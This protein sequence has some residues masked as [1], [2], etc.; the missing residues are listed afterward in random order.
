MGRLAKKRVHHGNGTG[1]NK[2]TKRR[3]RDFDEIYT[4]LQR[5]SIEKT[6]KH[7]TSTINEDLPGLGQFY[8]IS[9]ARYFINKSALEIHQTTKGH[10]KRHK[11]LHS[12]PWTTED[13]L[14]KAIDNGKSRRQKEENS[15][16]DY[17]MEDFEMASEPK[18]LSESV[19]SQS[20][21]LFSSITLRST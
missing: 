16:P 11:S 15:K 14:G 8:C 3:T 6:M 18:P 7:M 12:K 2:K 4:D 5:E 10:K 21:N 20:F 13:A 19:I 17:R 1:I 9:C